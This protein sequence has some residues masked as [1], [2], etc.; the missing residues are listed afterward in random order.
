MDLVLIKVSSFAAI[1][2]VGMLAGRSGKLGKGTGE[3]IS[4]IVFNFTLPAAIVH[5]FG[6]ADFTP[7]MLMLVPL[8]ICCTFGPYLLTLLFSRR[9]SHEDRVLYLMN[10]SGL[11]IGSFGLPFVQAFFPASTVVAACMF[12]AGNALMMTGGTFAL[13]RVLESGDTVEH[14]IKTV[15]KRLFSSIPFDSYLALIALALFGIQIPEAVVLFS[16]PMANANGFLSMFMLGLMVSFTVDG[17]RIHKLVNI[18]SSRLVLS[19]L[20]SVLVFTLLPFGYNIRCI[21]TVLLW[22]PIASMGPVFT[23]WLGGD[24]GL[25]GLANTLSIFLGIVIMTGI[26]IATGMV[27]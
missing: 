14:P 3:A 18:L 10:V 5:A 9:S 6:S 21:I 4:K 17:E 7:Q 8:G 23:L 20:M 22:A 11:N 19:G 16:E 25:A 1:I 24:H 27:I 15:L 12:D 13:T 26:V 2:I